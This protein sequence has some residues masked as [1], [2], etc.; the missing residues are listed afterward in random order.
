[1]TLEQLRPRLGHLLEFPARLLLSAGLTPD[2]CSAIAFGASIAA[3]V[4]FAFTQVAWG[5]FLVGV[6]ALLDGVDGA[7]ARQLGTAGVRGD[8]LDH[9][10]DRYADI[11]IIAGIIAGGLA[12][13][14]IGIFGL[15]G[16]LMTSY[17]GTQ[18]QAVGISRYYG[19][20]LGR[21]DRLLLI[22]LAGLITLAVPAG[23]MG[24]PWMG[25]LLLIFGIFGH[26]TAIQ[27]F[28]YVW[29]RIT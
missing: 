6:N 29:R 9:V 1:M 20:T 28:V 16:V 8:F 17:M 7:M 18:A 25:W 22:M 26:A 10:L 5:V 15:T 27:R 2:G 11:C 19:G 3:G 21:A 13:W 24:L 4:A 23:W 12:P 14:P